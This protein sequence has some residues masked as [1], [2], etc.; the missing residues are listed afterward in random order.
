MSPR[1]KKRSRT[2]SESSYLSGTSFMSSSSSSLSNAGG[3]GGESYSFKAPDGG[4]GWV[5]YDWSGRR[6][7]DCGFCEIS[8]NYYDGVF[9]QSFST[10]FQISM[11]QINCLT[12]EQCY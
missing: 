1:K 4:W 8:I 10:F 12:P 6:N 7:P 9:E 2:L 11:S 5:S 3:G